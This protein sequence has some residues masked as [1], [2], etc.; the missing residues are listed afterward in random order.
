MPEQGDLMRQTR[1]RERFAVQMYGSC[2][3]REEAGQHFQQRGFARSVVAFD[4]D[5]LASTQG[6]VDRPEHGFGVARVSKRRSLEQRRRF[7]DDGIHAA[8]MLPARTALAKRDGSQ[9]LS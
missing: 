8:R 7:I 5:N 1:Q 3:R 6:E 9:Y 2:G 4:K